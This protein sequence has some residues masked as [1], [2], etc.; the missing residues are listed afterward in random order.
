MSPMAGYT[1]VG[2]IAIIVAALIGA[3]G[4]SFDDNGKK[5][6]AHA[7]LGLASVPLV[8][9]VLTLLKFWIPWLWNLVF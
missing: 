9:G 7:C 4:A 3:I 5:Q 1:L 2:V 8:F 6:A